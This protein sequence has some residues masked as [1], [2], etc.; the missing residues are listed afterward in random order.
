ML[1]LPAPATVV[2]GPGRLACA[3]GASAEGYARCTPGGMATYSLAPHVTRRSTDDTPQWHY[4]MSFLIVMP[5]LTALAV[6]MAFLFHA[7]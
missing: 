7:G 1:V 4:G 5:L 6:L 3:G 2:R